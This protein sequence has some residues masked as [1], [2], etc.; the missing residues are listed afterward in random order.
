MDAVRIEHFFAHALGIEEGK[1]GEVNDAD[2][3]RSGEPKYLVRALDEALP[4]L[5][6]RAES[7]PESGHMKMW[8]DH[9]VGDM[10]IVQESISRL[11]ASDGISEC[12]LPAL[13]PF[14][15]LGE[16]S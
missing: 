5:R 10:Q 13:E 11:A 8:I 9:S 3:V 16:P 2:Y 6:K 4:R 14:G 7:L 15:D 1:R 12:V